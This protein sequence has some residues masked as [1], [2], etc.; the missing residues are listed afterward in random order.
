[1]KGVVCV[2]VCVSKAFGVC[3]VCEEAAVYTAYAS[4]FHTHTL[5]P[6]PPP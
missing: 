3:L 6:R 5:A 2:C 1:M 4:L